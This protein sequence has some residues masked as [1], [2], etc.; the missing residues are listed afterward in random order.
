MTKFQ[1]IK[2]IFVACFLL[3]VAVS[4]HAAEITVNSD[5]QSIGVGE[6]FEAGF[7]LNTKY[8]DINAVEGKIIFPETLLELKEIR[9]GNSII[10]FWIERPK[11][12]GGEVLFSGIIPGGYSSK[13]GLIMS[14]IFQSLQE[15]RGSIKVRDIK[16]LLNDGKGTETDTAISNLQFMISKQAPTPQPTAI[17]KKD[18]DMPEV[19]EPIV[20][21]DTTVFEGKYFLVFTTQDKGSGIDHYEVREG[22]RPFVIA[23]SPY[24]LQN[25]NLD[26]EIIVKAVDKNGNER[27]AV[28]PSQK[29]GVWYKNYLL[30]AILI[31]GA[32]LV[33]YIIWIWR[34]LW[35]KYR[36]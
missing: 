15:G 3:F 28:V 6:Q 22:E 27:I 25:Q 34:F 13:K 5:T 2:I 21:S 9:D 8:E 14:V 35:K 12:S 24:L 4:V 36:K 16:V 26:K 31:I 32:L 18:I 20:T 23:E 30:F 33:V 29:P 1:K 11:A 10:N 17:E 19:F 7:F